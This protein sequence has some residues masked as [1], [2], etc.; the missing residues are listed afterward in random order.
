MHCMQHIDYREVDVKVVIFRKFF[1]RRNRNMRGAHF[2]PFFF[3]Y[4]KVLGG[5]ERCEAGRPADYV[6]GETLHS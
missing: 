4:K 2:F 3:F 5:R 1:A 6:P